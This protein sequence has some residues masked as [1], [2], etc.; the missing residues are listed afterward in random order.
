LYPP[1]IASRRGLAAFSSADFWR[2]ANV[3]ARSYLEVFDVGIARVFLLAHRLLL[4]A[5]WRR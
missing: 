4:Y 5:S 1:V 3:R 2:V